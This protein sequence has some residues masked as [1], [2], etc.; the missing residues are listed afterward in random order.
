LADTLVGKL[1]VSTV[2]KSA[3]LKVVQMVEQMVVSWAA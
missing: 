1:V 3:A 2:V